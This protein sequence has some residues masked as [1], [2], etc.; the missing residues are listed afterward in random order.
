MNV[1][2]LRHGG[3]FF[4]WCIRV[5][6]GSPYAHA[7]LEFTDGNRFTTVVGHTACFEAPLKPQQEH[8]YD[9]V[10]VSITPAQEGIISAF[11][12]REV[13]C[14]YDWKG[15]LLSQMLGLGREDPNKW[16]CSEL[17]AVALSLAIPEWPP[18]KP[19]KTSPARLYEILMDLRKPLP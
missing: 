19:C 9:R 18:V 10:W 8:D 11:C 2:F 3:G 12:G 1:L 16:F 6:T 7:E 17:C 13:G 4:G 5:W 15:I 14:A